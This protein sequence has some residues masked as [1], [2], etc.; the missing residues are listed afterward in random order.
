MQGNYIAFLDDDDFWHKNY[1]YDAFNE[2]I[3]KKNL[4]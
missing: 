2:I 3:N 4:I 1:L